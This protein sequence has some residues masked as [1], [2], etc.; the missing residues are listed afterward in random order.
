MYIAFT[1]APSLSELV[2]GQPGPVDTTRRVCR[3][4]QVRSDILHNKTKVLLLPN[5][6][7]LLNRSLQVVLGVT[8]RFI[9]T[10]RLTVAY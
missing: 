3:I 10:H 9:K 1:N 4:S 7:E 8:V 6:P 2:R 5:V